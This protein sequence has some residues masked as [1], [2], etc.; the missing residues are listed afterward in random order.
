[1]I[2]CPTLWLSLDARW[3]MLK[4]RLYFTAG[5]NHVSQR[6]LYV[7]TRYQDLAV[8]HPRGSGALHGIAIQW[9][10][11][12]WALHPV[13]W[14]A[15]LY[16]SSALDSLERL[17]FI[18]TLRCASGSC[19]VGWPFPCLP[20]AQSTRFDWAGVVWK[21]RRSAPGPNGPNDTIG[22]P[23][24]ASLSI[25]LPKDVGQFMSHS[26]HQLFSADP[27]LVPRFLEVGGGFCSR[28]DC[29]GWHQDGI[30]VS[31]VTLRTS[32]NIPQ[33]LDG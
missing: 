25:I 22:N 31:T 5:L 4:D 27:R 10:S 21:L 18:H 26:R 11:G 6:G 20:S 15:K 19:F 17:P 12:C 1:M 9:Y 28:V 2:Y 32:S 13:F 14:L 7:S 29:S 3:D 24:I 33:L 16:N 8:R 23:V 30:E